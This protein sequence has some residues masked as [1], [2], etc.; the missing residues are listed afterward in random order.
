M[1]GWRQRG[2]KEEKEGDW[3]DFNQCT[4]CWCWVSSGCIIGCC[5][6][7]L[8]LTTRLP[9]CGCSLPFLP[10]ACLHFAPGGQ[11]QLLY[12]R[13][14]SISKMQ[15][16]SRWLVR[17]V[18]LS[19]AIPNTCRSCRRRLSTHRNPFI[20]SSAASTSSPSASSP[21][22]PELSPSAQSHLAA[23]SARILD[24]HR[25]SISQAITLLESTLPLHRQQANHLLALLA[26]AAKHRTAQQ[27]IQPHRRDLRIGISGAPG[28]GK[29]TLIEKL[30]QWIVDGRVRQH[31]HSNEAFSS[32]TAQQIKAERRARRK[33]AASSDGA[34]AA[35]SSQPAASSSSAAS[36][37]ASSSAAAASNHL[38]I[39]TV[40]PSSH[41][42][43]GSIL[44]D[45]TRMPTLS[46]HPSVYIRPSPSKLSLGGLHP[47]T[48]DA[49]LLLQYADYNVSVVETV[50]VGQSEVSVR[51]MVDVMVLVVG[52]AGGDEL[53][54]MKKGIVELADV[55][56]VNKADG[57]MEAA[58][59]HTY[60]DY[61]HAVQLMAGVRRDG[62][63][64]PQPAVLMCSSVDETGQSV[65]NV[66]EAVLC[67]D[68]WLGTERKRQRRGESECVV[69]M[70]HV[71]LTLWSVLMGSERGK[72]AVAA[73]EEQVRR[74]ELNV[75]LGAQ[76]VV[77]A[78]LRGWSREHDSAEESSHAGTADATAPAKQQHANNR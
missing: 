35:L 62:L 73:V 53:Q 16:V 38:A 18:W 9:P 6:E 70:E 58:A 67:V 50:G 3:I 27:P 1:K 78:M 42:T 28:V 55:V 61:Q 25:P 52:P 48:Y 77:E 47:A 72:R 39:L 2:E 40:D 7:Q 17:D 23:L 66:W 65:R 56:V 59:R 37:A 69:M 29:S 34:S 21:L 76:R 57:S 20:A 4:C 19:L 74:G 10:A 60:T 12:Q 31:Q 44:G 30:G 32:E 71:P 51:D 22:F 43:G 5:T 36:T 41:L 64:R 14:T 15:P 49:L 33:E 54:G 68:D 13:H 46:S 24:R 63:L 45:R 11:L 26:A 8:R 75:R